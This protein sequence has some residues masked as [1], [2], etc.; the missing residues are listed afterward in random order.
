MNFVIN[1]FLIILPFIIWL[2][3][4]HIYG[5]IAKK[6]DLPYHEYL[7]LGLLLAPLAPFI[8]YN[9]IRKNR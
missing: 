2:F 3:P 5:K 4:A 8:L 7:M 6:N 1:I 9:E